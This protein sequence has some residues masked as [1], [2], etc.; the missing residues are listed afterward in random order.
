MVYLKNSHDPDFN[1]RD[2]SPQPRNKAEPNDP[3][4]SP[5]GPGSSMASWEFPHP[6]RCNWENHPKKS[7]K[8][9]DRNDDFP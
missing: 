3:A 1:I 4:G 6:W 9:T 5:C 7:S 2:F 8:S